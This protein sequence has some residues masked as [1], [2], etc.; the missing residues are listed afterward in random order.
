MSLCSRVADGILTGNQMLNDG[1][2]QQTKQDLSKK[3]SLEVSFL[4][5]NINKNNASVN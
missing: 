5:K 1:R 3:Y 4:L 2:E